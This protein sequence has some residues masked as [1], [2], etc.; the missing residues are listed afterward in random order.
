MRT[1]GSGHGAEMHE[2]RQWVDRNVVVPQA[3]ADLMKHVRK[4][5]ADHQ[6][7]DCRIGPGIAGEQAVWVWS[8]AGVFFVFHLTEQQR[9]RIELKSGTMSFRGRRRSDRPAPTTLPLVIKQVEF[10]QEP[11]VAGQPIVLTLTSSTQPGFDLP[12]AATLELIRPGVGHE[13]HW[14][15]PPL[16]AQL[17]GPTRLQFAPLHE[18]SGSPPLTDLLPVFITVWHVPDTTDPWGRVPISPP[19]G[20]LLDLK[21][22]EQERQRAL[23]RKLQ[24]GT[25]D[26]SAKIRTYNFPQGRVTDHRIG[27]SLH[28]L[29]EILDGGLDELVSALKLAREEEVL[30]TG[31]DG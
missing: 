27:L 31:A 14:A 4:A 17:D 6:D 10:E 25:G 3:R 5:E 22:A 1:T 19:V 30:R 8:V 18:G 9:R 7:F 11:L 12:W 23:D 26:R 13:Q 15:Y 21:L 16:G 20:R 28:R 2:A 29:Q 24:V